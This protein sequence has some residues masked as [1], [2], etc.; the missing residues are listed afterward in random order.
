MAGFWDCYICLLMIF[1]FVS[2]CAA[3]PFDKLRANGSFRESFKKLLTVA[4]INSRQ[5]P[6]QILRINRHHRRHAATQ[7]KQR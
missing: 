2:I 3:L 1:H 6:I 4:R 7:T 5:S